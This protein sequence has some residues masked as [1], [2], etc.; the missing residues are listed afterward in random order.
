MS[1]H[2]GTSDSGNV[3]VCKR[4]LGI[5]WEAIAL[6]QPQESPI[7]EL[8]ETHEEL[9]NSKCRICR[10]LATIKPSSLNGAPCSVQTYSARAMSYSM[11]SKS[12]NLRD[13]ILLGVNAQRESPFIGITCN[14]LDYDFGVRQVQ[15]NA[16]D[17]DFLKE[18]WHRC[19][20]SHEFICDTTTAD[21]NPTER[22]NIRVI[23]CNSPSFDVI[24]ASQKTQYAA[25]SY[26]WGNPSPPKHSRFS[27]IVEDAIKATLAMGLGYL[28]VDQYVRFFHFFFSDCDVV[29]SSY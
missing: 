12:S 11:K 19:Q 18:R 1:S 10:I 8:P 22:P 29:F 17:F 7:M 2:D 21:V 13:S 15:A 3:D 26:V 27:Q 28:W 23:D 5:D 14:S 25:L 24:S 20:N 16:V 6:G 4:C 9:S